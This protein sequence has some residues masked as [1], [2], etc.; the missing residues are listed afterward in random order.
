MSHSGRRQIPFLRVISN[1]REQVLRTSS[2]H[3]SREGIE[4]TGTVNHG[5]S[6]RSTRGGAALEV[7]QELLL[8]NKGAQHPGA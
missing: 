3:K 2:H 8:S 1:H 5:A 7:L 6:L 4:E